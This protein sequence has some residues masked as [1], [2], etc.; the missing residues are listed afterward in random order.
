MRF[1][2]TGTGTGLRSLAWGWDSLLP[3]CPSQFLST[4][5]EC[6]TSCSTCICCCCFSTATTSLH[7]TVSSLPLLPVST[8]LTR[9]D[10]CFFKSL[11]VGPPYCLIFWQLWLFFGFRLVVILLMVVRGAK[12]VYLLLHFSQ[13]FSKLFLKIY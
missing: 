3:S 1:Y 10:E 8:P 12:D 11:V 2:F 6:G 9:L 5:C 13:K 4:T 7:H